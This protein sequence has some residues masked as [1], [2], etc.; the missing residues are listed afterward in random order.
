MQE[1]ERAAADDR[2][3]DSRSDRRRREGRREVALK[4]LA[5]KLVALDR[6]HLVR[7]ELPEE[8]FDAI[9]SA[10]AMRSDH[11]RSRQVGVV[12]QLLRGDVADEVQA[13]LDRLFDGPRPA[14]E[15][16]PVELEA[17]GWRER[18]LG[19]G[20]ESLEELLSRH[21]AP[22][23]R[24]ELRKLVR[25]VARGADE[26]GRARATQRLGDAIVALLRSSAVSRDDA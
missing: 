8:L 2:S 17:D 10:Q 15:R 12:R 4:R 23:R 26:K 9:G 25:A 20:D 6:R 18:L 3:L 19:G 24:Q 14:R 16:T 13:R 21:D 1:A 22:D 7:L 11:A 5:Q